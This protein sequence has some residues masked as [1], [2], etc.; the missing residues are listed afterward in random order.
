MR[1]TDWGPMQFVFR[2]GTEGILDITGTPAGSNPSGQVYR[3]SGPYRLVGGRLVSPAIHEGRPVEVRPKDG[4][5]ILI[6]DK[7]LWFR[8]RRAVP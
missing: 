6:V 2:I 1:D 5:L 4:E 3:R 7:T 8:L